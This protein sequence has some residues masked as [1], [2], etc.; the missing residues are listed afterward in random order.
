MFYVCPTEGCTRSRECAFVLKFYF[1]Q[2]PGNYVLR[3]KA[4]KRASRLLQTLHAHLLFSVSM[5]DV[6]RR[7]SLDTYE[8]SKRCD[9]CVER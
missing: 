2:V 1:V 7:V 8:R 9:A 4:T 5:W 3:K 6:A